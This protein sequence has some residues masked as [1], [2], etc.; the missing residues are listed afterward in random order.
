ML[1][2]AVTAG[3]VG[4]AQAQDAIPSS[5]IFKSAQ[6]IYDM[7]TSSV[8]TEVEYCD[9]FIM[10]SH[11]M[12]KLYG[13]TGLGGSMICLPTGTV[14]GDVRRVMIAYWESDRGG[15]EYSAVSTIYNALVEE[16]PCE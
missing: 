14:L 3:T 5:G 2:L 9:Y 10:S 12:I 6:Q 8:A 11:D 4:P 7:C 15:L 1:A 16:Y 13:D